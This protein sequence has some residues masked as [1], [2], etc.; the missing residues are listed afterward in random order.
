[1]YLNM[2]DRMPVRKN[3]HKAN[4]ILALWLLL[5]FIIQH[6]HILTSLSSCPYYINYFTNTCIR[7]ENFWNGISTDLD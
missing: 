2:A 6:L 1:M 5:S 7:F 4:F 3:S